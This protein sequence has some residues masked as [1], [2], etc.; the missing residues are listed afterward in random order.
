VHAVYDINRLRMHAAKKG[1]NRVQ[2]KELL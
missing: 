1:T 2:K